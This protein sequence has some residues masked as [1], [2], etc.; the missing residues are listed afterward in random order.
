MLKIEVGLQY[1]VGDLECDDSPIG[2]PNGF[3]WGFARAQRPMIIMANDA[4]DMLN[5]P[6]C[7]EGDDLR[8]S[9]A[10]V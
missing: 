2:C 6:R 8:L 10:Y 9:L 4:R 1:V 3:F 7:L 5:F